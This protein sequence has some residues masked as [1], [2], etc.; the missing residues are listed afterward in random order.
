MPT[1]IWVVDLRGGKLIFERAAEFRAHIGTLKPGQYELTLRKRV[2]RRGSAANRYFHG[3]VLAIM[4][5]AWGWDKDD[6]KYELRRKFLQGDDITKPPRS[7]ADLDSAEFA[8]FVDDCR[9]LAAEGGIAIPDP[10]SAE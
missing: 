6:L 10:N 8:R 9:R 7:T 4:A 5:E 2:N 1:P 3:V